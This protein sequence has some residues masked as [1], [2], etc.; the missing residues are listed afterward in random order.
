MILKKIKTGKIVLFAVMFIFLSGLS[1]PVMHAKEFE[2]NAPVTLDYKDANLS[3]VLRALSHSYDLNLVVT[4][5]L[6]GK[7]TV[8]LSDVSIDEALE[9]I[10]S[11]NGYTFIRKGQLIFIKG[12]EEVDKETILVDLSYLTAAEAE[13]LISNVISGQGG[14]QVN[15]STNGLVITDF[16]VYLAKIK[17]VLNKIDVPP[18]QVLIEAKIVDIQSKAF[19]NLGTTIDLTYDPKGSDVS[20]GLFDRNSLA[21]ESTDFNTSLAGPSSSLSGGQVGFHAILKS[22][23]TNVTIDALI[24]D[25][26][27]HLLASPSIATLNGKEARIIIGEKF[28]YTEKTQTTTGTTETT[29]FVDVGTTLKVTPLVSPDG[30]ITMTVHPEVSSVSAALDAGPRITTREADATIRVRDKQTIIIGGLINK[31]DDRIEGGV[32]ILRSIPILG[33][34]FSKRSV[35]LEETELTVFI[36]P[37]IIKTPQQIAAQDD[38]VEEEVYLEIDSIGDLNLISKLFEHARNLESRN[39]AESANKTKLVRKQ[40]ILNTYK[41]ILS[42]FPNTEN[43]DYALYKMGR[44]YLKD[45]KRY[46]A[47]RETFEKLIEAHPDSRFKKKAENGIR[48]AQEKLEARSKL[49]HESDSEQL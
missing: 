45:F 35:D 31:K 39:S 3:T 40:E 29:R 12:L 13:R 44:L 26:K 24:Q 27:A 17:D 4:K 20:G 22:L 48:R 25:N 10:L 19:E 33:F 16:P 7:V 11:V 42:Q 34:L 30:W 21:A 8:N 14:V 38:V 43:A 36:T 18:I 46:E 37:R 2:E 41:L 1:A 23:D 15:E 32:P 9:A 49:T 47:A 28:P 5:D 6:T